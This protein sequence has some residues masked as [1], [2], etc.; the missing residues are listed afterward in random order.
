MGPLEQRP[1]RELLR[2]AGTELYVT[3]FGR[4]HGETVA[5]RHQRG[6]AQPRA[7]TE[8]ETRPAIA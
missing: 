3:R 6:G 5:E 2:L 7:G 4:Q 8:D 1:E